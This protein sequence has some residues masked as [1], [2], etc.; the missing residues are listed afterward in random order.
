MFFL[1]CDEEL[2]VRCWIINLNYVALYHRV[3][4]ACQKIFK[5]EGF[6]PSLT[7]F[8]DSFSAYVATK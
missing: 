2:V 7:V 5:F 6:V 1:L 4:I 3:K 8:F